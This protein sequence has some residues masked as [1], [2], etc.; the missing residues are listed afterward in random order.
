MVYVE[1]TAFFGI[2]TVDP[3]VAAF[4]RRVVMV[5]WQEHY[6]IKTFSLNALFE[7]GKS[8]SIKFFN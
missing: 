2:I 7:I 8:E 5:V 4:N 3:H 6:I 1:E